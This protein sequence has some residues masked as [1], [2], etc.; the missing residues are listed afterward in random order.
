MTT[1]KPTILYRT[2]GL[3]LLSSFALSSCAPEER[4]GFRDEEAASQETEAVDQDDEDTYSGDSLVAEV[5]DPVEFQQC[6]DAENIDGATVEWLD[7]VVIPEEELEGLS[8]DTVEVD[9]QTVEVPGAPAIVIPERVGQGGCLIEYPAPGGCLPAVEIS[10]SFIPGYRI[11]ERTVPAVELPDGTVLHELVQ[12]EIISPAVEQEGEYQEQVC[13]TEPDDAE[14]GD[15]IA[16]VYRPHIHRPHIYAS[17]SHNSREN[18]LGVTTESGDRVPSTRLPSYRVDSM[19]VDS[20]RVDSDRLDSYRVEGTEHTE[21]SEHDETTSYTTEGDVLFDS[22]QHALRSEAETELQ[23][24][25]DDIGERDESYTIRVEGHTDDLPS[26]EYADNAELSEQRAE[27]V[28]EWLRDNTTVSSGDV[29]AEGMGEDHPRADN[30]S[31]EGRQQ[32][33]RVVITVIPKDYE[34]EIDYEVDGSD[35]DAQ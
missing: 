18:R 23:A 22:D 15:H 20:A 19:R 26:Q 2:L 29:T 34:P 4:A 14:E 3:A 13:Q 28:V 24:I 1:S 9:G 6:L 7:D 10:G 33:R 25:A 35:V 16:H 21:Y 30:N 31:E 27:A 5:D 8:A 17:R 11:P 12:E 32:N